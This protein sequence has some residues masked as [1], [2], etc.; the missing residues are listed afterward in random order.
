MVEAPLLGEPPVV[1]FAN[2]IYA[3]RG[4]L[5]DGLRTREQLRE[6]LGLHADALG[7]S[8][9]AVARAPLGRM[10]RLRDDVRACLAAVVRGAE[11]PEEALAHINR[12]SAAAPVALRLEGTS[13]GELR[14][15]ADVFGEAV[16]AAPGAIARAA[17]ELLGGPLRTGLRACGAP[18]CVL[19]F[20]KDHPRREWCSVTCGNRARVARHYQRT[21]TLRH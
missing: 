3:Q 14:P 8:P 5:R 21:R 15:V 17:I 9:R 20:V 11:L 2:T 6:W 10:R 7:L 4:E 19:F 1:E 12:A 16:D 13:P 18:G